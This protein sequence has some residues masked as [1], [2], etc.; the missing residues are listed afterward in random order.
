[1]H[2]L[3]ILLLLLLSSQAHSWFILPLRQDRKWTANNKPSSTSWLTDINSL[4]DCIP[5]SHSRNV[6]VSVDAVAV[7]NRPNT[8]TARGVAIYSNS[9]C[10]AKDPKVRQSVKIGT[11]VPDVLLLLDQDLLNGVHLFDI[12]DIGVQTSV[13]FYKAIDPVKE[14][15]SEDGLLWE[16]GLRPG[17]YWWD[18]IG[19]WRRVRHLGDQGRMKY[20][21]GSVADNL[22][23]PSGLYHYIRLLLEYFINPDR[24]GEDEEEAVEP[25]KRI[26]EKR[27][28]LD[29]AH[30]EEAVTTSAPPKPIQTSDPTSE[31]EPEP[32]RQTGAKKEEPEGQ[33]G[34]REMRQQSTTQSLLQVP[35]LPLISLP[36]NRQ[37]ELLQFGTRLSDFK[38]QILKGMQQILGV[39]GL[40]NPS[41]FQGLEYGVNFGEPSPRVRG[42]VGGG[43]DA[44]AADRVRGR[45]G[46]REQNDNDDDSDD[47]VAYVNDDEDDINVLRKY[48]KV[49]R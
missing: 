45:G 29:V 25:Y 41:P 39:N 14:A 9:F 5:Y 13:K 28:G 42:Q 20:V 19:T 1:M 7:Y 17:V 35:T 37:N 11:H 27:A 33:E 32:D 46:L 38:L 15:G 23:S 44:E 3:S 26:A 47:G 12:K 4:T 34:V 21:H 36:W 6:P 16:S 30:E 43:I 8:A 49:N 2:L 40:I 10:G 18:G 24:M 31:S 22:V 48:R